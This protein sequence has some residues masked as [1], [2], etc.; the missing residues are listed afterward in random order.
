MLMLRVLYC[1]KT[2]DNENQSYVPPEK[3]T[4]KEIK[5]EK[6]CH[7]LNQVLELHLS[8]LSSLV[9]LDAIACPQHNLLCINL[10]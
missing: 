5:T 7:P 10:L 9:Q 6:L 2:W 1:L 8:P 3:Y 4:K